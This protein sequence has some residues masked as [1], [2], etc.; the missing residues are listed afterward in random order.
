MNQIFELTIIGSNSAISTFDRFP[1]A[2]ILQIQNQLILIDCGEGTQFRLDTFKIKKSA[3]NFIFIS[4]LHGDHYYGLIG[5][6]TSFNLSGRTTE[7]RLFGPPGLKE[8]IDLQM[9]YNGAILQYPLVFQATSMNPTATL[10]ANEMFEVSSF[11]L[12][13]RI[14]TTGFLFREKVGQRKI[15][16]EKIEAF[17]LSVDDILSIKAGE[18]FI[19]SDGQ[20]IPSAT[21]LLEA[22]KAR[23]YAYCSDTKYVEDLVKNIEGVTCLYHEATFETEKE[24]LAEK[25]MHSTSK[26]AASIAKNAGVDRLLIGH[27]SS[28]Y[29]DLSILL[30][31]ARA[32]FKNTDLA[33]EGQKY[34]L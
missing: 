29:K 1:T 17:Q 13:H 27:F 14:D 3:I 15:R 23:S 8:I 33:I 20:T 22:S 2:Q 31:E 16:K 6:L 28:R 25:T 9:K 7:L 12:Q 5:L 21:F 32:V 24:H 30:G 18:D 4:H 10:F 19:T 34:E 26:Q 11:P